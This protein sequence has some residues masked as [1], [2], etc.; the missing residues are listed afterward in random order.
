MVVTTDTR[1]PVRDA[2]VIAAGVLIAVLVVWVV[3]SFATADD[4]LDCAVDNAERAQDGRP[5]LDCD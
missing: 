2:L 1:N 3:Y 5:A 4:G